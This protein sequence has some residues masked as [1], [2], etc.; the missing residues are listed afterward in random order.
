MTIDPHRFAD[1]VSGEARE[2]LADDSTV[3]PPGASIEVLRQHYGRF[4]ERRLAE[5]RAA[6]QV[7]IAEVELAGVPCHLVEPAGGARHA[8]QLI[9]L[10]GGAFMWGAGA[11][12]LLEAVPVAAVSG[13]RVIAV[14]YRLA[15][16]HCFPAAVEDVV[17]VYRRLLAEGSAARLGIY[18]CSAGAALTAQAVA[19]MIRDRLPVPGGI[20]MLHAAGLE[21][22]G[23]S[24]MTAPL[25][26]PPP[27]AAA[28]SFA[29]MPY[30]ASTTP[31][32]PL[33]LPGNHPE[34][35]RHF[36]PAL[37]VTA[38]RDFAASSVSVMHRRLLAAG[39]AA[40]FMLFDGM[41]HAHHMATTLPESRETFAALARFFARVLE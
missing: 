10:H 33:A 24:A 18:G 26:Q 3:P 6:Y 13:M 15:P 5:S 1:W 19:R 16:E 25:F 39:V 32:D 2:A 23:D 9:C 29:T 34:L 4:N 28:P 7:A 27:A 20:A 22:A 31:D 21:L 8:G 17:A 14:E 41:G 12:A 38:T 40:E 11:G 30:F 37:L 36:P 35:L